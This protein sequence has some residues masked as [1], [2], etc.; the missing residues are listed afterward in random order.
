MPS[1]RVLFR[2]L[3]CIV[4]L[5]LLAMIA[6]EWHALLTNERRQVGSLA[7]GGL[8]VL[9]VIVWIWHLTKRR[10]KPAQQCRSQKPVDKESVPN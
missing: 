3:F 5:E 7:T 8:L 6:Q 2:I 1:R 9:V 4:C 10:T